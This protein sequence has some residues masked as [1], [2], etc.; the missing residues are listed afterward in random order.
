MA[1]AKAAT[2]EKRIAALAKYLDVD[3]GDIE[4][5]RDGEYSVGN[6]EYLVL[7]DAEA[8]RRTEE[9]IKDS[10]WAFNA[11]FIVEHSKLPHEAVK[12]VR[13]FQEAQS[14]RAN[15]TIAALIDDMDEFVAAAIQA[16]G[17][18]HFLSGYDGAENEE[19]GF[20][21]YRTN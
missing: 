3:K 14:E 21:I 2:G 5:V 17:R 13:G 18:G 1:K 9:Y 4:E 10:L 16:D 6:Q 11:D 7:T 15:E 12:M 8:D 20:F 19:G